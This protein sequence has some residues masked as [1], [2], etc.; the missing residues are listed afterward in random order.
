[1]GKITGNP[2][3]DFKNSLYLYKAQ[4]SEIALALSTPINLW[5]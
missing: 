2:A 4:S 5:G 3:F 1:M